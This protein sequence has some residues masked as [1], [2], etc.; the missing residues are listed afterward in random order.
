MW[1]ANQPAVTGVAVWHKKVGDP[2]YA[3]LNE[4]ECVYCEVRTECFNSFRQ[5]LVLERVIMDHAIE[6]VGEWSYTRCAKSW[7]TVYSV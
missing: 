2:Y 3:A 4:T 5:T 7:Y 1:P 6:A